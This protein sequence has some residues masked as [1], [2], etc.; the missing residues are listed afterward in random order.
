MNCSIRR[1]PT[2]NKITEVKDQNGKESKLFIQIAKHPLLNTT[3][4]AFNVYKNIFSLGEES[5][6]TFTHSINGATTTSFKDA[7]RKANEGDN[8]SLGFTKGGKFTKI[9]EI[10]KNTDVNSELGFIQNTI[11]NNLLAEERVRV[12]DDYRLQSAGETEVMKAVT[13][14]RLESE[15]RAYLGTVD[16]DENTFAFKKTNDVIQAVKK[17][18][19]VESIKQKDFQSMSYEEMHKYDNADDLLAQQ[20]YLQR[21]ITRTIEK[22]PIELKSEEDL[23]GRLKNFLNKLGVTTTSIENYVKNY[24]IRNGVSPNAT[25]LADISNMVIAFSQGE[26]N[27][28]EFTE[29]VGHF[30]V[31]ALPAEKTENILRNIEKSEE[32]KQ[33]SELYRA[34]YAD[35]YQGEELETII[36]KEVLGKIV[37]NSILS[38][39]EENISET[40]KNFFDKAIDLIADFLSSIA[41][42]FKPDYRT[43][44]NDY[45]QDVQNLIDADQANINTN[46]KDSVFRFYNL[47]ANNTENDKILKSLRTILGQLKTQERDLQK[48]NQNSPTTRLAL[49][50]IERQF[51]DTLQLHSVRQLMQ[52]IQQSSDYIKAAIEDSISKSNTWSLT[53]T[54]NIIF[55]NLTNTLRLSINEVGDHIQK[56]ES[57][58]KDR[59][60]QE[61]ASSILNISED[62]NKLEAVKKN[63]TT[64]ALERMIDKETVDRG[65][66]TTTRD[67]LR[68]WTLRA[69][70]EVNFVQAT[71]GTL[72]NA[73]DSMLSLLGMQ[74]IKISDKSNRDFVRTTKAFQDKISKLGFTEKDVSQFVDGKD[75]IR[76]EVDIA[77]FEAQKDKNF[78][79]AY[80]EVTGDKDT[81]DEEVIAK[82]NKGELNLTAEQDQEISLKSSE[83]NEEE[84]VRRMLPKYYDDLKEV[85]KKSNTSLKTQMKLRA[86]ISETQAIKARAS[87]IGNAL[88][89]SSLSMQDKLRLNQLEEGRLQAKS[90]TAENGELKQGLRFAKDEE[91]ANITDEKGRPVIE[92]DPDIKLSDEALIAHD[93]NNIDRSLPKEDKEFPLTFIDGLK[94]LPK[95]KQLEYLKLNA[96]TGFSADYWNSIGGGKSTVDKLRKA[97]EDS[98]ENSEEIDEIINTILEH[99]F[100]SRNIIKNHAFKNNPSEINV[101]T[102]SNLELDTVKQSQEVLEQSFAD[103]KPFI[104]DIDLGEN[105]SEPLGKTSINEAYKNRLKDEGIDIEE[106]SILRTIKEKTDKQIDFAR[107]YM[108]RANSKLVQDIYRNL[109]SFLEGRRKNLPKSLIRFMDANSYTENDLT[110]TPTALKI[111]R[112]FSESRLLPYYKKYTPE[113]YNKFQEDLNNADDISTVLE[114]LSDYNYVE[115]T[116]NYSFYDTQNSQL[117]PEYINNSGFGYEQPRF[118][119]YEDTWFT[120][121]FGTVTRD[122]QGNY[123]TSEKNS[124]L[125]ELYKE[126]INF[127]KQQLSDMDVAKGHNIYTMP[128]IRKQTVERVVDFVKNIGSTGTN[129]KNAWES[130]MSYTEDEQVNGQRLGTQ[131]NIIPKMYINKLD[132][133]EDLTTDLFSALVLRNKEAQLYKARMEFYPNIMALKDA[134]D[135]REYTSGREASSTQTYKMADSAIQ[136]SLYGVKQ[137]MNIPFNTAFG[138]TDLGQVINKTSAFLR[139]K[140]LGGSLIVPATAYLTGKGQQIIERTVG[141]YIDNRSYK[142]GQAMQNKMMV[143]GAKEFGKINTTASINVW[144]QHFGAFELEHS[145]NNSKYGGIARNVPRTAMS[146]YSAVT[147]A[148]YGSNMFTVL[149]D[150]RVVNG[151]V[152]KSTDFIKSYILQGKTKEEAKK[153]WA[154]YENS[155]IASYISDKDGQV[156]F[157]KER[158]SKDLGIGEDEIDNR[159]E[160]INSDIAMQIKVLNIKVDLQLDH[161]TKTA[162]QRNSLLNSLMMFKGYM[163]VAFENRFRNER[164]N[165]EIRQQ[166]I[167]SYNDAYKFLGGIIREWKTNGH[168]LMKAFKDSYY[169]KDMEFQRVRLQEL[170]RIKDERIKTFEAL[171][172]QRPLT[173]EE[174]NMKNN[175]MNQDELDE[176]HSLGEGVF[177][178]FERAELRRASLKR[179]GVD[180]AFVN[181]LML[182]SMLLRGLADDDKD[183]KIYSLQLANYMT[184]RFVTEMHQASLGMGNNYLEVMQNPLQAFDSVKSVGDSMDFFSDNEKKQSKMFNKML[185]LYGELNRLSDPATAFDAKVYFQ[186]VKSNT[187][188]SIPIYDLMNKTK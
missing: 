175:P 66:S 23:R 101:E 28:A 52:I 131:G 170:H 62:L 88:D 61:I 55:H 33:F 123:L 78:V 15:A 60:W 129:I 158:L 14:T 132:H 149:N 108:T 155:V 166:E 173:E 51:D 160:D 188:S 128:Q 91:G 44:L 107:K 159:I 32:W 100:R 117:N 84:V 102:M 24:T 31:E 141:Q 67:N 35:E 19:S 83:A 180:L 114:N 154:N 2:T 161:T 181:G 5:D 163:V 82:A 68:K 112:E 139:F 133:A 187:F 11:V 8:I 144:G 185:P 1:N 165:P 10:K 145:L 7:L 9:A 25:A 53:P 80:R 27:L 147:Y 4:D 85:Y 58:R 118:S 164:F 178:N 168:S 26:G 69:E 172:K 99:S 143:E 71:F 64:D 135:T 49:N 151:K 140:A 150:L 56:I 57:L 30:I 22:A 41:S 65:L 186:E 37:R 105:D 93:L 48:S 111:V 110:D 146:M 50:E 169:G 79:T 17:D 20:I 171:E 29:E 162:A 156:I 122:E 74:T 95:S 70:S 46:L 36:K 40:Q 38:R 42:Y 179:I 153:D 34:V 77:K 116:P 47:N 138:K 6:L 76:S 39:A 75:F 184:Y 121:K 177:T 167:G 86:Y 113:S 3:E 59:E 81:K 87:K 183:K 43:E 106:S 137:S 54:E 126:T 90:Y 182:I 18:G 63:T 109:E 125:F 119:K 124:K 73:G 12:G 97:K 89:L 142:L 96:F 16:R 21:P 13:A 103:A 130:A 136:Y 174:Q 72:L 134:I 94:G 115:I 157:D 45:L 148:I 176:I 120:K 104:K 98:P 152:V 92:I 127:N